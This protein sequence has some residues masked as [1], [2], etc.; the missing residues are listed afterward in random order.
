MLIVIVLVLTIVLTVWLGDEYC[1]VFAYPVALVCGV[2]L[3]ASLVTLPLHRV[4]V[5]AQIHQYEAVRQTVEEARANDLSLESAA[6]QAKVAEMNQWR[7]NARYWRLTIFRDWWPA[8]V[9]D[10]DP[11]R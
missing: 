1:W 5:Q 11:I 3:F 7:A 9:A 6:I 10:L 4:S 2:L 8:A